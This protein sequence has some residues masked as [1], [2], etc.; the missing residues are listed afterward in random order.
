MV[1]GEV[2]LLS[3]CLGLTSS[4]VRM[5]VT[6]IPFPLLAFPLFWGIIGYVHKLAIQDG[7]KGSRF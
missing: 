1:H 6:H 2:R 7:S 5:L 3:E 4:F